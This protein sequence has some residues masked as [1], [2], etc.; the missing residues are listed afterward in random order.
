[1]AEWA[2]DV[3]VGAEQARRLIRGQFPQLATGSLELIGEGFDVTVWRV[4]TD[5]VFRFPRRAVVIEGLLR[6]RSVL[7]AVAPHLPVGIPAA[8][9]AGEPALGYPYP[10]LGSRYLPGEE[11]ADTGRELAVDIARFLRALHSLDPA[12]VG[13]GELPVDPLS[14]AEPAVRVPRALARFDELEEAGVWSAP[15]AARAALETALE[16]GPAEGRRLLHGDLHLRNVLA[17][18]GRLSG[19]IDWIDVCLGDP[20]I[21]LSLYWSLVAPEDRP[22]FREAYGLIGPDRLLRA[23]VLALFLTATLALH[24]HVEGLPAA[25]AAAIAG[26]DRASR[27]E[28]DS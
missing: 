9:F 1:M 28:R 4:D 3:A 26:L 21:D 16:L 17:A 6:E 20:A 22:A 27:D 23:R 18:G 13:G 7:P 5:W 14:R 19:V 10:F 25:T 11:P 12:A 15:A 24:G 2:A 8:V